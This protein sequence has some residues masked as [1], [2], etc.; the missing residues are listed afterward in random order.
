MTMPRRDF[1]KAAAAAGATAAIAG[2]AGMPGGPSSGRVV[3]VGGGYGG[4]TAAKYIRMWSDGRIDVTLVEPNTTFVSCPLSNLVLGGSKTLADISTPYDG[5][6]RNHGVK[7]VRDMVSSQQETVALDALFPG[8]DDGVVHGEEQAVRVQAPQEVLRVLEE[9]AGLTRGM[10]SVLAAM[11][12]PH[13][14]AWLSW[15]CCRPIESV[16]F[17]WSCR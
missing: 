5:L 10:I 17:A 1:L 12:I 9:T 15:N 8:I 16:N 4:A 14:A 6:S 13:S 11:S 3:V 2:C 7:V